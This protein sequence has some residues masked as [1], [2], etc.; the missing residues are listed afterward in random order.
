M[1]VVNILHVLSRFEAGGIEKWLLDFH[2]VQSSKAKIRHNFLCIS[3]KVGVW[4]DLIDSPIYHA[5]NLASGKI[6]FFWNL[7]KFARQRKN[8]FDLIHLHLYKFSSLISMA[9]WLCGMRNIVAHAH[10]DKR[11]LSNGKSVLGRVIASVY[12][13]VTKLLFKIS[14]RCCVAASQGAA[15]DVFGSMCEE[16][17]KII[18]CGIRLVNL[19]SDS[20]NSSYMEEFGGEDIIPFFNVASLTEQKNQKF[21]IDVFERVMLED[22]RV[23]L[24]IVGDGPLRSDINLLI[25]SKGLTNK[26][27]LLGNRS[28][29]LSLLQ[30]FSKA[31]VFPSL[32]EGLGLALVEAQYCG[33]LCFISDGIPEEAIVEP[34][35]ICRLP[36]DVGLW[37]KTLVH[38]LDKIKQGSPV[39]RP[40]NHFSINV[41]ANNF[42]HLYLSMIG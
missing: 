12:N 40:E 11:V 27:F 2:K 25:K 16:K 24:F 5:P 19:K 13:L 20:D 36:L 9:F 1:K 28:D 33:N 29:V 7:F 39:V 35:L 21:L 23:R 10:N 38:Y 8:D 3:G 15:D 41:S 34:D 42:H 14:T 4:D 6:A 30:N 37:S 26:V 18:Y 32:Y 17:T 22:Q 31:F